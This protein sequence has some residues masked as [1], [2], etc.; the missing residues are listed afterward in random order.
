MGR[1]AVIGEETAVAGYTLA[2]A[3]VV[4]A[5]DDAALRQAW[6]CLGDDVEVVVLTRRAADVLEAVRSAT[7][8]PLTVVMPS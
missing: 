3:L 7:N 6:A 5:E 4:S 1:V 2:G 8:R